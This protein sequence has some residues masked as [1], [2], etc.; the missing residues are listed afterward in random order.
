MCANFFRIAFPKLQGNFTFTVEMIFF[1][2]T[3]FIVFTFGF[4]L[5]TDTAWTVPNSLDIDDDLAIL[6]L[7]SYIKQNLTTLHAITTTFGNANST[8]TYPDALQLVQEISKVYKTF[9]LFLVHVHFLNPP[10][11]ITYG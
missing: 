10:I 3:F 8:G 5:D 2:F 4:I 1:Y 6:Y 9:C 11:T 7:A